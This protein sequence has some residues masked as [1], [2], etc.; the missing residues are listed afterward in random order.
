[1]TTLTENNAV[2]VVHYEY[3]HPYLGILHLQFQDTQLIRLDFSS[4]SQTH[5]RPSSAI[6]QALD[7]YFLDKQDITLPCFYQGTPFQQRVWESISVIPFGQTCTY[8][9][10]AKKLKTCA[11]A[12]GQA[13]K[14][15]PVPIIVPCH[16]VIAMRSVG[17][18]AGQSSGRYLKIKK[19]LLNH[20]KSN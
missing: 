18:Y 16:R 7:R 20:E 13:L 10:L 3:P 1:M 8:G 15:N 17:G 14:R 6:S 2:K 5:A 11:Q 19:W 4:T 12:V 9:E